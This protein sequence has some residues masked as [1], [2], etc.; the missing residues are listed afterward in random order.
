MEDSTT[1]LCVPVA[2]PGALF[3]PPFPL[4]ALFGGRIKPISQMRTEKLRTVRKSGVP[5]NSSS[6]CLYN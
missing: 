5:C 3:L 4:F 6:A 1:S 2:G